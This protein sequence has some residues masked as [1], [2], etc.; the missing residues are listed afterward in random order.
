MRRPTTALPA[1]LLAAALAIAG[2]V[3]PAASACPFCAAPMLT[4]SEQ[5]SQ[6]DVAVIGEWAEA[7]EGDDET[8]ARDV[9]ES[10][11]SA[12]PLLMA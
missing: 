4:L 5:I 9:D 2:T 3:P 7:S 11:A 10:E 12:E 1:L 8:P 6:A